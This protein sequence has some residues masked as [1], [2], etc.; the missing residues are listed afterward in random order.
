MANKRRMII[1]VLVLFAS[2]LTGCES[3]VAGFHEAMWSGNLEKAEALLAEKPTLVDA[4]KDGRIP[5]FEALQ[6]DQRHMVLLLIDSGVD[7]NVQDKVGFTPLHYAAQH[8]YA[9]ITERLIARG[10]NVN[11]TDMMGQT[12][13]HLAAKV[14][15]KDVVVILL[16][17][18]ADVNAENPKQ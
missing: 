17:G 11:A 4:E 18:G 10:V 7:V 2:L 1:A 14:G 3:R 6:E 16:A 5:L 13:L 9:E 8:G 12:P 15:Y